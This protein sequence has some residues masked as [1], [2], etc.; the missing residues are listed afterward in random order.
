MIMEGGVRVASERKF[1]RK[2][3]ESGRRERK[4]IKSLEGND[5]RA[6]AIEQGEPSRPEAPAPPSSGPSL[7][8][9]PP[10][11]DAERVTPCG[12]VL[13]SVLKKGGAEGA[14]R[15]PLHSRCLG[16]K[17]SSFFS[18]FFL[19]F[20]SLS[21]LSLSLSLSRLSHAIPR[22]NQ[23]KPHNDT[24][25]LRGTPPKLGRDFHQVCRGGEGHGRAGGGG[26]RER[27]V[28]FL[29]QFFSSFFFFLP[30]VTKSSLFSLS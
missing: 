14:E 22:R 15:P 5:S 18:F 23:N 4:K 6:M 3:E 29:F 1:V 8:P 17:R 7:P 10:P 21:S 9:P 25:A 13:K 2:R 24:S 27:S 16:E 20:P 12:G 26:R 11:A 30:V 28:F 19:P